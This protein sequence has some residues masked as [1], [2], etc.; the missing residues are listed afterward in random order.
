MTMTTYRTRCP[1]C[2]ATRDVDVR[3]GDYTDWVGG[4][5]VQDAFPYLSDS[6]REALVTGICDVCWDQV[7][8]DEEE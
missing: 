8:A 2:G 1:F 5:H 7:F 4:K 3:P 6:E